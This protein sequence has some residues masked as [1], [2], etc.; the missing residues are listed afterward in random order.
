MQSAR[1]YFQILMKLEF[2]REI[3][4]NTQI[5]NFIKTVQWESRCY[6]WA[7]PQDEANNRFLQF[8]ERA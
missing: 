2:S 4:K 7:D 3:L 5:S 6:M 1:Y 8:C